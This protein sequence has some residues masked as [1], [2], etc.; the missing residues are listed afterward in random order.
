[1]KNKEENAPEEVKKKKITFKKVMEKIVMVLFV[2]FF[3]PF[4]LLGVLWGFI[5]YTFQT[6][7]YSIRPTVR[8]DK[9]QEE[10]KI[11]E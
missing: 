5:V 6:G 11:I 1:M 2:L 7:F 3:I 10:D 4:G 8:G 9:L